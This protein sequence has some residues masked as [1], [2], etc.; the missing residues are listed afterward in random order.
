MPVDVQI[1]DTKAIRVDHGT[2]TIPVAE[3]QNVT[4]DARLDIKGE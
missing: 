4:V 2:V 1:G 3:G